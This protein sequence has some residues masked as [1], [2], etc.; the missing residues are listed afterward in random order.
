MANLIAKYTA[1]LRREMVS[2]GPLRGSSWTGRREQAKVL[3]S[4]MLIATPAIALD[5]PFP[6]ALGLMIVAAMVALGGTALIMVVGLQT[7]A[8]AGDKRY[9][10]F[11][12]K[13]LSAEYQKSDKNGA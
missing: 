10:M 1:Y 5:L 3:L 8:R 13:R 2:A 12:R 7:A 6:V 9:N 4:G 11:T